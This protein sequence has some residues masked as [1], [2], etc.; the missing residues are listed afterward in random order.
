[1]ITEEQLIELLRDPGYG[2]NNEEIARNAAAIGYQNAIDSRIPAAQQDE[3]QA[4]L[5]KIMIALAPTLV[6]ISPAP[7]GENGYYPMIVHNLHAMIAAKMFWEAREGDRIKRM[8]ER[9]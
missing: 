9:K 8:E 2:G 1:M 7:A 3:K 4:F 6:S 5:D